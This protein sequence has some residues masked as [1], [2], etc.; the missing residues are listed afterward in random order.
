MKASVKLIVIIGVFAVFGTIS[1]AVFGSEIPTQ[2][3][4][5]NETFDQA[6]KHYLQ[7]TRMADASALSAARPIEDADFS[8]LTRWSSVE[9]EKYFERVR[10]DRFLSLSERPD[11]LRRSSWLFPDDGCFARAA[12]TGRRLS[13]WGVSR[14][15]KLFIFGQLRVRTPNGPA[16]VGGSV[17]WWYHVASVVSQAGRIYVLDPAIFPKN[18]V[19]FDDWVE[20]MVDDPKTVRV[21][22]CEAYSYEPGSSCLSSTPSDEAAATEQQHD[23]LRSEWSRLEQLGRSAEREL[24]DSPPWVR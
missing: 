6:L 12:V 21:A 23:F 2:M 19:L 13:Q 24:G 22:V 3:R 20:A 18:A 16:G 9:L 14:P 1:Q 5:E 4:A 8:R 15:K 7:S 17:Y 10:D 11:F